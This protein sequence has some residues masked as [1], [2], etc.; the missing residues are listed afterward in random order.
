MEKTERERYIEREI[1]RDILREKEGIIMRR[2][3]KDNKRA[4]D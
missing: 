3:R 4:M 2:V 1:E